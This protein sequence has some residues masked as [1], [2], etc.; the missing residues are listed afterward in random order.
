[1]NERNTNGGIQVSTAILLLWSLFLVPTA[2]TQTYEIGSVLKW[3][4]KTYSQSANITRNH[5][6]YSVR[7]GDVV[8]QIARRSTQ[9]EM[10]AGQQIQCRVA[11][12][13]MFVVNE[14]GKETK[15]DIV[16]SGP[17]ASK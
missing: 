6:V 5:P 12:G 11:N 2:W 14:K 17:T 7:V 16:G 9:V 8:Y 10:N 4:T 1:M 15:Y 3:E 13:Q